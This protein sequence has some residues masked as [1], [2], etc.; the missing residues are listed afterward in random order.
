M[1]TGVER[2]RGLERDGIATDRARWNLSAAALYEE[3]VRRD[4]GCDRRRRAAGLPDRASTP[5]DR[6]TT[7]SSSASRRARP[8]SPGARSTGRWTPAQFDLLHRDLLSSLDGKDLF[9]QDCYAG[10]D[11]KYRL[12]VRVITEYAWHNLFARN[13]FIDDPAAAQ[14]A[15]PQFT[16][17]DA[18]SFKADPA[19]HGTSSDVVIAVNFAKRLVLIGGTSYAGEMKKSIFSVLNYLLPLQGVLPMHC[20]ANVGAGRRRG[21]VLRPV[22]HRQDDAVERSR[23][24]ADRRRRARLER[25]RRVQ[26]RGRL[27]REDDP[28]VGR[29]RAADLRDDAAVRHGARERGRRSGH[30]R[31]SNLDDDR[32][33]RE[34]ARRVSDFVHRQRGAVRAGRPSEEHRHAD[35][36]RV[37]RAAADLAA[38]A[39]RRDVSL[40]VRLHRQGGG[41]REGR[42]RAEGDV[43]HLLRRAVP[44]AGRRAATREMLGEKIARHSARVWLV[45]TG[46]TGGPYGVGTR[47]KIALHARDDPRRAVG[48][49]RRRGVREGSGLQP[50]RPDELSRTCRPRC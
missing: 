27:L 6:R 45:N 2:A 39:G 33:H 25:S 17:I 32:L 12:P 49:A 11:P 34:H 28:A 37:R 21:A 29:G 46:W 35:R 9:V 8:R 47:M 4:E 23:A 22:G 24:Q 43:Q 48:R 16:V 36:R 40:P 31:S 42:D 26:L 19:R 38:D 20:S 3:A 41:H 13:L 50:R 15:S 10:A 1:S 5:A 44:A 18:P 14:A 7:S 30:A